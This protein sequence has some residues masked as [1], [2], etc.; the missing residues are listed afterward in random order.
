[1][2]LTPFAKFFITVVILGVIGY[3]L[4][5][6][7]GT[8]HPQVGGRREG[9]G[10]TAAPQDRGRRHRPTT[11]T[12]SRT[13]RPT[14]SAARARRACPARRSPAPASSAG[15]SSWRSTRGRAT[16]RASWPRAAWRATPTSRYKQT[17]RSRREVR[18]PRGPGR[19][20]R[21]LPQGR[22]GHHVEHG[23][24]LGARG[25]DPGR[26][27]PEGEVDHHAGLV[28]RRRRHRLAL[29]DQVHRGPQGP[30]DRLHA[31]HAVALPPALPPLAVGPL[32]GGPRRGREEHHLHAGRAGRRGHVQGEAGGRGRDVGA[33]SLGGGDGARRRGA[34]PRLHD[35]RHEHHRGH[36]VRPAGPHRPRPGH[37]PRLRPRLVRRHRDDQGRPG[38]RVR[39]RRQGAEARHGHRLGDALRPEAHALRRQR[40]VLRPRGRQGRTTRRSSTRPSSSGG[41][42]GS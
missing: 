19:Q 14:P 39:R 15:R 21:R 42:R 29:H 36:A 37:G 24:Q 2:K 3:A 1:M 9:R 6:Y 13:R 38:R 30:E 27:E 12:R 10:R 28:A 41:R 32:G 40:A 8:G 33:G 23:G 31:V 18:P 26:A 11:S 4:W 5:H 35:G 17:L 7:K 16:L 25:L 20:A 34:R 22:R